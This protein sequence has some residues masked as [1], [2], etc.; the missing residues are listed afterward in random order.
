MRDIPIR[1]REWFK[2]ERSDFL[3]KKWTGGKDAPATRP[4]AW[5]WGYGRHWTFIR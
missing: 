3:Y 2:G 5:K 4:R 1:K